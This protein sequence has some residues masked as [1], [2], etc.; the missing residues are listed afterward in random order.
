MLAATTELDWIDSAELQ[1]RH[2]GLTVCSESTE[3]AIAVKT[4]VGWDIEESTKG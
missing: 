3:R 4:T 1:K 2:E